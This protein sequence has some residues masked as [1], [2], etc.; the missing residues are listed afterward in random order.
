MCPSAKSRNMVEMND[1]TWGGGGF[2]VG[3]DRLWGGAGAGG[4]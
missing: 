1:V 2:G 3:V 4:S